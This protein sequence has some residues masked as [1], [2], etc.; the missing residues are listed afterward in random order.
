MNRKIQLLDCTLRDGSYIVDAKFGAKAIGGIIK[1]LQDAKVD[2]IEAGWLK[3]SEHKYGTAFYH[4]P[5]DLEQ[6]LLAPKDPNATYVAMID[7]NRYDINTLTPYTGRSIDA[8]RVVFPRGKEDEGLALADPIREKGYKVYLQIANTLGYTDAELIT[9]IEKVNKVKPVGVSIV[10][11][12]GAMYGEDLQRIMSLFVHNLDKDIKIGFHSHNNLQLSFALSIQF[13]DYLV[14]LG[15]EIIVD[16][17]LC[18]MGRGAGNA[19][20]ELVTGFLNRKYSMNYDIDVIMDAIDTY[21]YQFMKNFEWGYS[22]PFYISG[23]YCTHVNNIDYL[24]KKHKAKS[25]DMKKIIETLPAEKR[26]VYDYDNLDEVYREYQK[27][28]VDDRESRNVLKEELC[29]KNIVLILPGKTSFSKKEEVERAI[30]ENGAVVIGVNAALEGY[31]YDYLF[32]SNQSRY[33]YVEEANSKALASA[34]LIVSSNIHTSIENLDK[35][36]MDYNSLIYLG[37]ASYESASMMALKLLNYLKPAKIL[38]AG[39]DG[40]DNSENYSDP[41][42]ESELTQAMKDEHNIQAAEMLRDYVSK[43]RGQIDIE[44]IT[45]SRFAEVL[46]KD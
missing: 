7:Y 17:S 30:S 16:S 33:D 43:T 20:T 6:Y 46:T 41:N 3:D 34:K 24:L 1:R 19:N 9:L 45:P 22:I 29:G 31:K 11:T 26:L 21:M 39:F 4:V 35:Y 38:I 8:I 40:Y 44:F 5:E 36:V 28:E 32:F 18:G 14:S 2:I 25:K 37:W 12:F 13:I 15:R 27:N 23:T 42:M 10:D